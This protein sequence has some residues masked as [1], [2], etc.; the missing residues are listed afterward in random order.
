MLRLH[1]ITNLHKNEKVYLTFTPPII[2][3]HPKKLRMIPLS[4]SNLTNNLFHKNR[5]DLVFK[6][7]GNLFHVFS[8]R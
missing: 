4:N 3:G 1:V 8:H 2:V 5:V 6:F 7:G